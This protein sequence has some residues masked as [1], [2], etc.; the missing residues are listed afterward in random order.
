MAIG[1][2][3]IA[4]F[5]SYPR[6]RVYSYECVENLKEPKSIHGVYFVVPP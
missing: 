5:A 2:S 6:K 3:L 1:E 4:G